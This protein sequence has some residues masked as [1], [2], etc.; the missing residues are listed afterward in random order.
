M[1]RLIKH[2]KKASHHHDLVALEHRQI[3]E[4][5]KLHAQHLDSEAR[6]HEAAHHRELS[7]RHSRLAKLHSE[8]STHCREMAEELEEGSSGDKVQGNDFVKTF[9]GLGED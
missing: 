6:I 2:L 5:H 4:L 7:T 3:G 1:D 9:L 8:H